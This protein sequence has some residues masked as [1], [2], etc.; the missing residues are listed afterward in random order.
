MVG[1]D[2]TFA[3]IEKEISREKVMEVKNFNSARFRNINF[4]LNK[5]EILA[6]AGLAGAGRTELMR[7]IFGEDKKDSG[8][9]FINGKEI[10]TNGAYRTIKEGIEYLPEDRKT[11]GLFLEMSIEKNIISSNLKQISWGIIL[12]NKK[13]AEVSVDYKNKLNIA[14]PS[15]KQ[16]VVNLSGG[17][18][19]KVVIAK[20]LFVNPRILIVDE[21]TRGVDVGA[22]S[23]IY[24][25]LRQLAGQ[26]V[27]IIMVSSDLPEVLS[28]GD[29]IYVMYAGEITGEITGKDANEEIIMKYASGLAEEVL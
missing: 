21:P 12:S 13:S 25:I 5:G 7:A 27:S 4:H 1:R 18:Q 23:E 29:R 15:I 9:V 14:T 2:L 3:R 11:N 24:S 22:K 8:Q 26:G 10:N 6:F 17:N 16:R 20:G 19:Q 28:I